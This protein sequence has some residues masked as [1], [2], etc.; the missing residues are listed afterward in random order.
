M[1]IHHYQSLTED[2]YY[3]AA[4]NTWGTALRSQ[5]DARNEMRKWCHSVFGSSEKLYNKPNKPRWIDDIMWGEVQFL[6]EKDL[7]L[8]LLRWS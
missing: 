7:I 4:F 1:K 6:N 3:V 8:F 2:G 5:Q